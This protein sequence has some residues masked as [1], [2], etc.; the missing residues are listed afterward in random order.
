MC[1]AIN[2]RKRDA[3]KQFG[4][5]WAK[6][7]MQP[8]DLPFEPKWPGEILANWLKTAKTHSFWKAVGI[9]ANFFV[10]LKGANNC[11]LSN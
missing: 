2:K 8:A 4:D 1:F 9:A 10:K 11:E 5:K 6:E 3:M 7:G